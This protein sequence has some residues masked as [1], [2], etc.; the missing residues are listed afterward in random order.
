MDDIIFIH[1]SMLNRYGNTLPA[2]MPVQGFGHRHTA[3]QTACAADSYDQ[4]PFSF[5]FIIGQ[6]EINK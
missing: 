6:E 4:L 3:M 5:F 1:I 2:Q